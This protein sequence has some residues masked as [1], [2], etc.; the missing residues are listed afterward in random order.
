MAK[1]VYLHSRA[2][3]L[4]RAPLEAHSGIY[5]SSKYPQPSGLA[6]CRQAKV[7]GESNE[8]VEESPALKTALERVFVVALTDSSALILDDTGS[9]IRICENAFD[10][11]LSSLRRCFENR[12]GRA[13]NAIQLLWT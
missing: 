8:I 6:S 13:P 4:L 9:D 10:S 5:L 11:P 12:I 1:A 2:A 3:D 7:R